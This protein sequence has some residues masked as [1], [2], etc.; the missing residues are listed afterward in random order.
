MHSLGSLGEAAHAKVAQ[1]S[2]AVNIQIFAGVSGEF[3]SARILLGTHSD[4]NSIFRRSFQSG[5]LSRTGAHRS[6]HANPSID[7]D[8]RSNDRFHR[9]SCYYFS[10]FTRVRAPPLQ[11]LN[12]PVGGAD[13]QEVNPNQALERP[14]HLGRRHLH[15]PRTFHR[16]VLDRVRLLECS[17]HCRAC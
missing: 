3:I 1:F 13:R 17:G 2:L 7:P 15:C 5:Y 6:S 11:T 4:G 8:C 14:Y 9:W 12:P 10:P 16:D